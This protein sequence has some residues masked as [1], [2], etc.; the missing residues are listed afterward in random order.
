MA[1]NDRH[2]IWGD[3]NLVFDDWKED[4]MEQYPEHSE[5]ELVQMMYE[6]NAEY[7]EDERANLNVQ[8][9]RPILVIADIGRWN[10]RFSGYREI[11]SGK[12]CD[13]LYTEMDMCE[14]Y[15]DNNGDFRADA[16]HHDGRNHYLYRVYKD[17]ATES[18]IE[19]LKEKI[20]EGKA[21]RADITR[22]TRR[23]GDEIAAVYGFSIP[24]QKQIAR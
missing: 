8:L 23:L 3:M 9:S 14:W 11:N 18:Q 1:K 10:G 15:V 20:Y 4:L 13:C 16:V 17:N 5:D 12:I 21:T 2:T 6:I 24:R 22:V 7:L 19:N